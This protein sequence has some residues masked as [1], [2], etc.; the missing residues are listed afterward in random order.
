MLGKSKALFDYLILDGIYIFMITANELRIGNW[1]NDVKGGSYNAPGFQQVQS[2]SSTGVNDYNDMGASSCAKF[3]D[4]EPIILSPEILEKCGFE[5]SDTS[6]NYILESDDHYEENW[7]A[8]PEENCYCIG[9]VEASHF[10]RC[11]FLHQLQNI[12]YSLRKKELEIKL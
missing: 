11:Y 9:Y 10:V 1:F 12:Y 8:E 3:E 6:N 5:K 2:I 7:K 4:I